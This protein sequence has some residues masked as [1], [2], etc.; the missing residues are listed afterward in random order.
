MTRVQYQLDEHISAAVAQGLVRRGII[1]IT[2]AAAGLLGVADEAQLAAARAAGRVLVT[3]DHD[4]LRLHDQGV[5]HAGIA[6]CQQGA[7]SVGQM[8]ARLALIWEIL[9]AEEMVGRVEFL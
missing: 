5:P 7:R 1:A 4:F 8:I 3:H 9:T 2:T 6:Y